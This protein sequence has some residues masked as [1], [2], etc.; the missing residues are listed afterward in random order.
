[1]H[2]ISISVREMWIVNFVLKRSFGRFDIFTAVSIKST[3]LWDVI[4]SEMLTS[5]N[6]TCITSHMTTTLKRNLILVTFTYRNMA[7]YRVTIK[8]FY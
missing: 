1:L 8:K 2:F 6:H 4:Q 5:V 3:V 7:N